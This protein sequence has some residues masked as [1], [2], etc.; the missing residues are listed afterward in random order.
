MHTEYNENTDQID[1]L[2]TYI[3][4]IQHE[5][6]YLRTKPEPH[7]DEHINNTLT[8]LEHRIRKLKQ[9]KDDLENREK[10][11]KARS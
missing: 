7:K 3:A 11:G 10:Q 5:I 2:K 4:V 9:Q 1:S 8:I 6:K